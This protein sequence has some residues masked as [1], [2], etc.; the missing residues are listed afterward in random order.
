MS[1]HVMEDVASLFLQGPS[2]RLRRKRLRPALILDKIHLQVDK[3]ICILHS[4]T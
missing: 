4:D 1:Q 3:H 2:Q